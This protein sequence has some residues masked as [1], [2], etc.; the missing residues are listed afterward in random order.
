MF[1]VN[2]L[3]TCSHVLLEK[4][5]NLVANFMYRIFALPQQLVTYSC[6]FIESYFIDYHN[7]VAQEV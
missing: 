4:I 7:S 3:A 1:T 5:V 6:A 2:L